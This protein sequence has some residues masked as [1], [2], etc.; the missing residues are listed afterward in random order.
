MFNDLASLESFSVSVKTLGVIDSDEEIVLK[1]IELFSSD[2]QVS[3]EIRNSGLH[4]NTENG[5]AS[6]SV[7]K[8]FTYF[9]YSESEETYFLVS[10]KFL[11]GEKFETNNLIAYKQSD[12][13]Q[14]NNFVCGSEFKEKVEAG[15]E[16]NSAKSSSGVCRKVRIACEADDEWTAHFGFGGGVAFIQSIM[17]DV[18]SYYTSQMGINVSIATLIINTNSDPYPDGNGMNGQTL[19]NSFR[20]NWNSNNGN[21]SRDG[22]VL[23]AYQNLVSNI[24]GAPIGGQVY[25]QFNYL[26]STSNAYMIIGNN[27]QA[28]YYPWITAHELGHLSGHPFHDDTPGSIMHTTSI[29]SSSFTTNSRNTILNY[30]EN[31]LDEQCIINN[32]IRLKR[33]G[34]LIQ[35]YSTNQACSFDWSSLNASGNHTI[36]WAFS[37]NSTGA[38]LNNTTGTSASLYH[39]GSSGFFTL[40]LSKA[41]DCGFTER[42]YPF[43]VN[44]CFA[45]SYYPN[46]VSDYLTVGFEKTNYDNLPDEIYLVNEQGEKVVFVLP[47]ETFKDQKNEEFT[48]KVVLDMKNLPNGIYF[49]KIYFRNRKSNNTETHRILKTN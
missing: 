32:N 14:T 48:D 12:V 10:G 39:G 2:A 13:K 20:S 17:A 3:S 27:N 15:V 42:F 45:Y 18:N 30:F 43:Q 37:S 9:R 41:N 23:F 47:K 5:N 11:E 25:N 38:F 35:P 6:L 24:N 7:F 49:L 8:G 29:T 21:I 31:N 28:F 36:T 44:N 34:W 26:C 40:K 33:N 4:F 46:E 1:R 19:V 16:S 22:A